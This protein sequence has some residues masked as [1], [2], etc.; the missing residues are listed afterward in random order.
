MP[1][2]FREGFSVALCN[3][4]CIFFR[5]TVGNGIG[6]IL[7]TEILQLVRYQR[8]LAN[9]KGISSL[10]GGVSRDFQTPLG[11]FFGVLQF[12]NSVVQVYEP[13]TYS[14][15]HPLRMHIILKHPSSFKI[16]FYFMTV[17]VRTQNSSQVFG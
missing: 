1:P 4:R 11:S 9:I 8:N 6:S 17:M 16:E 12:T 5:E 3:H 10:D 7:E 13:I 15:P 14:L 2:S